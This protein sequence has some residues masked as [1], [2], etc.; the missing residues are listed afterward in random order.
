MNLGKYSNRWVTSRIRDR[1]LN[2]GLMGR[3]APA[4]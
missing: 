2:L 3:G 4:L 1:G